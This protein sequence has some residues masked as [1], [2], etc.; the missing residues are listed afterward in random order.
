MF[1]VVDL[2]G[3]IILKWILKTVPAVNWKHM[4]Q[5]WLLCTW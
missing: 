5:L 4:A 2:T 3:R 1:D